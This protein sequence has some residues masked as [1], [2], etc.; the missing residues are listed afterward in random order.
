MKIAGMTNGKEVTGG[1]N[2]GSLSKFCGPELHA[3]QNFPKQQMFEAASGGSK[4]MPNLIHRCTRNRLRGQVSLLTSEE[5]H[6][7]MHEHV[8]RITDKYTKV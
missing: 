6:C 7:M 5:G 2:A 4:E 3:L 8:Q 1:A